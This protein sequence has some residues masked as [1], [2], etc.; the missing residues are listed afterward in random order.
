ARPPLLH[1]VDLARDGHG[2]AAA[3]AA[4]ALAAAHTAERTFTGQITEPVR[5]ESRDAGFERIHRMARE[6]EA[7]CLALAFAAHALA[8]LGHDG[9]VPQRRGGLDAIIRGE[10]EEIV[11]ARF[12]RF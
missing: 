3:E 6:V 12:D 11:L 9:R 8:P 4:V 2:L 7:E 5:H 10:P 1:F